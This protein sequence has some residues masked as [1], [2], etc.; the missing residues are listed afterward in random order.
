EVPSTI[1]SSVQAVVGKHPG[2]SQLTEIEA[3]TSVARAAQGDQGT[4]LERRRGGKIRARR[5]DVAK[6]V[7]GGR[8]IGER[9]RLLLHAVRGLAL[10]D[11]AS[12][13]RRRFGYT[14]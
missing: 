2:R 12:R 14:A 5:R 13:K 7:R 3:M 6:N 8:A 11:S 4:A 9:V 10:D 1:R